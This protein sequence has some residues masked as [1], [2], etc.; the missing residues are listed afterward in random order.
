MKSI[1]PHT[2]E[3]FL[4]TPGNGWTPYYIYIQCTLVFTQSIGAGEMLRDQTYLNLREFYA[5]NLIS[6]KACCINQLNIKRI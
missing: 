3:I 4:K 1:V 6:E 2:P 5:V